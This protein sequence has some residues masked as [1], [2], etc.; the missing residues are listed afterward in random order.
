MKSTRDRSVSYYTMSI[1]DA[2]LE[3]RRL[4]PHFDLI[5]QMLV[6]FW[7]NIRIFH[8][9]LGRYHIAN[10]MNALISTSCSSHLYLHIPILAYCLTIFTPFI[11]CT[12]FGSI[13]LS[14]DTAPAL[15]NA[16]NKVCSIDRMDG[17]LSIPNQLNVEDLA[18]RHWDSLLH[19]LKT[20]AIKA[21]HQGNLGLVK[22][23]W[24]CAEWAG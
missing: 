23:L 14:S 11:C 17:L 8:N 19:A 7:D 3:K 5:R 4:T 15:H 22:T 10:S 18:C 6:D 1:Q 13:E 16:S 24:F 2:T 20:S 21:E 9:Q 12:F